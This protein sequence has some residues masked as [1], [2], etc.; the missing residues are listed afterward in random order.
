MTCS[1]DQKNGEQHHALG[2]LPERESTHRFCCG[3]QHPDLTI[4]GAMDSI[5]ETGR[6]D[7]TRLEPFIQGVLTLEPRGDCRAQKFARNRIRCQERRYHVV[8]ILSY[9][10][11]SRSFPADE[12]MTQSSPPGSPNS[13]RSASIFRSSEANRL[14][15]RA[16]KFRSAPLEAGSTL[17][18]YRILRPLGQGAMGVV[19]EAEQSKLHRRVALK[20]L[21]QSRS[22]STDAL[23]RFKR[24][25]EAGGRL[26]HPGIVT[27]YDF[28]HVDGVQYIAQELVPGARDLADVL[29]E[30]RAMPQI[31][32]GFYREAAEVVAEIAEALDVAHEAGVIHR[33]IKPA[34]ILVTAEGNPKIAD[35]G[36][37]KVEDALTLSMTGDVIGTPFY[38]SPEQA[39]AR[40]GGINARTDVFSLG[41]TLYELLTLRRP[42][43]G[44]TAQQVFEMILHEDPVE[45]RKLRQNVPAELS[46]ICMKAM[47][48]RSEDRYASMAKMAGDL[49]RY[50]AN[51]PI[52]A[53]PPGS[54][55][56][57]QKWVLRHPTRSAVLGIGTAALIIVSALLVRT[58][59]AEHDARQSMQLAQR[60]ELLASEAQQREARE[61]KRAEAERNNVLRLS[62]LRRLRDLKARSDALWPIHPDR[63]ELLEGWLAD[64]KDLLASLPSHRASLAQ[65]RRRS[66][67]P[68]EV[69]SP[70]LV[71][72]A[73]AEDAW[74]YEMLH[75]LVSDL[76]AFGSTETADNLVTSIQGRFARSHTIEQRSLLDFEEEWDDSIFFIAESVTY[77]GL[78]IEPQMG[79]VPLGPDPE[80][81]FWEFWL[82]E[83][84]ESPDRDEE[85]GKLSIHGETGMVLVLLPGGFSLLGSQSASR[86]AP[87]YVARG[88]QIQESP[89][90]PVT[91]S[92]F[93]L[94]KYEM[95]QGQWLRII[96]VNPSSWNE[97]DRIAWSGA[98]ARMHPVESVSWDD[99]SRALS[100]VGLVLPTEA[101]WEYG[102][103]AGTDTPWWTGSEPE[104]LK[105]A[106][107]LGDIRFAR[108]LTN[109]QRW[110][111]WLDDGYAFHA[112][113]GSFRGNAF[114]LHDVVGNVQEWCR[115]WFGL[116]ETE[117][118]DGDGL[119]SVQRQEGSSRVIRSG[120]FSS[121]AT[122]ARSAARTGS[123]PEYRNPNLGV[124]AA[125]VLDR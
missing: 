123:P 44:D 6:A 17:G 80:S 22:L 104:S 43:D 69:T 100:R 85:T 8:L 110:E 11:T 93:F 116:Y 92:A 119:R 62:D 94:S 54:M 99:C 58:L 117:L 87:H 122:L 39:Q 89:V 61:R 27:V 40:R 59:K 112:P 118:A 90:H 38:M 55:R 66:S 31:P 47:E 120:G 102:A 48:K 15:P 30:A 13:D 46:I 76:T 50:L 24:E 71:K 114:G 32:R 34:N 52:L 108:A 18:D 77:D 36:L 124:R 68:E 65:V 2:D 57:L 98:N 33:D 91:L 81:G 109:V 42:F 75:S 96:G 16:R 97:E 64:A 19:Y 20:V 70:S 28:G 72:F 115:D 113:V 14:E 82:V 125:R 103:R 29:H 63:V 45:P 1:P 105:G 79:L 83:S 5:S 23:D 21:S 53:R 73:N 95:T 12:Q 121:S 107:N 26:S 106:A 7:W 88:A 60:R 4:A 49:R 101:Q 67:S 9:R 84:G 78:E 86:H 3:A 10:L 51:E 37:A 111:D 41:A 35:F 74:W 56:R 25:A